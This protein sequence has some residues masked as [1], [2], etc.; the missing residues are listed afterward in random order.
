MNNTIVNCRTFYDL[1]HPVLVD[2]KFWDEENEQYI[3]IQ[4]TTQCEFATALVDNGIGT[5]NILILNPNGGKHA[6]TE[7]KINKITKT[8]KQICHSLPYHEGDFEDFISK[9][10]DKDYEK[11]YR[12][13]YPCVALFIN[14]DKTD[15]L[16]SIINKTPIQKLSIKEK[17]IRY[18]DALKIFFSTNE[19]SNISFL[20]TIQINI[21][22]KQCP[23]ELYNELDEFNKFILTELNAI[24]REYSMYCHFIDKSRSGSINENDEPTHT[25]FLTFSYANYNK[26]ISNDNSDEITT[27][28]SSSETNKK[29]KISQT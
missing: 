6:Y 28:S 11:T 21:D 5:N 3:I 25:L 23:N 13:L 1:L 2:N 19:F 9:E 26:L 20:I 22:E 18:I 4:D 8:T 27:N 10:N 15:K 12:T 17:Q 29:R 24:F 7:K 14:L 16:I